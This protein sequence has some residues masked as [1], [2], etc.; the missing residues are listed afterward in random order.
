[1]YD[2]VVSLGGNCEVAQH[3]RRWSGI[4]IAS[5]F[6]WWITPFSAVEKLFKERFTR[7]AEFDNMQVINEGRTVMCRHYGIALHHDF[8]RHENSQIDMSAVEDNSREAREKY[9]FVSNRFLNRLE[10]SSKTLFIR[11]WRDDLD[12]GPPNSR[13]PD[14][15][16][17]YDFNNLISR[18]DDTVGHSRFDV[19]FVNYGLQKSESSRAFFHNIVDYVDAVDWSGSIRGWNEMFERYVGRHSVQELAR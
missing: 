14:G 12:P 8:L 5:P 18:L 17:R 10:R 1:M 15:L 16:V 11:S 13:A 19:L 3:W 9:R 6:D 2:N 4:D 7:L